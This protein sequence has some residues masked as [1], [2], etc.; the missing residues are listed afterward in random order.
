MKI[1]TYP[2][3]GISNV[4]LNPKKDVVISIVDPGNKHPEVSTGVS[5]LKL[6]FDDINDEALSFVE[7]FFL[8]HV[9]NEKR[10]KLYQ[11]LFG[12]SW[13]NTPF[14]K[15][16]AQKV[17]EFSRFQSRGYEKDWHI[18]CEYGRSRSVAIAIFLT[19]LFPK[20]ELCLMRDCS[21]PNPR[22]YRILTKAYGVA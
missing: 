6:S 16:H 1:I 14:T 8:E 18:H 19:F 9:N 22:V 15:F 12:G 7:R 2:K 20:H 3:G 11:A 4:A 5:S 13:G 10:L 21:R 17:I